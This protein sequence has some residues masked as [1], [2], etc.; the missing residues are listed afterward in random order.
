MA[1]GVSGDAVTTMRASHPRPRA[2]RQER[3][4]CPFRSKRYG[5]IILETGPQPS[6]HH[7][8]T[9]RG[10]Q[11]TRTSARSGYR[12]ACTLQVWVWAPFAARC[13]GTITEGGTSFEPSKWEHG[14]GQVASSAKRM[15]NNRP[16]GGLA[17]FSSLLVPARNHPIPQFLGTRESGRSHR[18][19]VPQPDARGD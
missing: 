16:P 8:S 5:G 3:R 6:I 11:P 7:A 14:C 13:A 9:R 19:L 2:P 12:Y 10:P 15:F 17:L 1:E 18:P 4:S